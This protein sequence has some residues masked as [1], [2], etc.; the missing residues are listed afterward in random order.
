MATASGEES[1]VEKLRSALRN[2]PSAKE[3]KGSITEMLDALAEEIAARKNAGDT[4][5]WIVRVLNEHGLKVSEATLA[6][7]WK[8]RKKDGR[9]ST[10]I[11]VPPIAVPQNS[12]AEP[13]SLPRSSAPKRNPLA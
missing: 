7:W 9:N 2:T 1:R 13:R 12:A 8:R 3:R 6:K 11:E 4:Y 5:Q 10:P